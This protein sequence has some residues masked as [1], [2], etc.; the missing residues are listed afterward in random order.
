MRCILRI[1]I[2]SKT[3]RFKT[4]RTFRTKPVKPKITHFKGPFEIFYQILYLHILLVK[5][6][7]LGLKSFSPK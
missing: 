1:C 3:P 4:Q 2:V 5:L 6:D 7:L